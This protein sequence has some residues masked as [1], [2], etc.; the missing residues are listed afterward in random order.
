MNEEN[1]WS[2]IHQL[3][4]Y[5]QDPADTTSKHATI[6]SSHVLTAKSSSKGN[7]RRQ[8]SIIDTKTELHE[9][10]Q[11]KPKSKARGKG[12]KEGQYLIQLVEVN[13]IEAK[14]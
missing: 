3:N 2:Y 8:L 7:E 6:H 4:F 14:R 13:R 1:I 10:N 12:K 9:Y 5:I 11:N